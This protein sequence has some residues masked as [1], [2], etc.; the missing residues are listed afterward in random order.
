MASY[1]RERGSELRADGGKRK[2]TPADLKAARQTATYKSGEIAPG[3]SLAISAT[4]SAICS[5][6]GPCFMPIGV[7]LM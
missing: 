4:G 6:P 2:A 1:A 3:A 5:G 7:Q